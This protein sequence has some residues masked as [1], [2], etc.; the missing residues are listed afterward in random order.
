[1]V[2]LFVT[3][4][5]MRQILHSP[6]AN[7]I[8]LTGPNFKLLQIYAVRAERFAKAAKRVSQTVTIQPSI[9]STQMMLK[10]AGVTK[11]IIR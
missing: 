4:W 3:A 7:V 5:H 8:L 10:I 6:Q 2:E 9:I 1:M 11:K